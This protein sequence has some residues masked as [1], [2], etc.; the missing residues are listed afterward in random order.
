M[1]LLPKISITRAVD[2]ASD[3]IKVGEDTLVGPWFILD[4][5]ERGCDLDYHGALDAQTVCRGERAL[6]LMGCSPEEVALVADELAAKGT[7]R[8]RVKRAWDIIYALRSK[9]EEE[10]Q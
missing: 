8:A 5:G 7:C 1:R 6:E 2:L 9:A 10:Q 4:R 3:Q